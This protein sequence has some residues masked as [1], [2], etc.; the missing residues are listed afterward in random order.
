MGKPIKLRRGLLGYGRMCYVQIRGPDLP[1]KWLLGQVVCE[2]P[3]RAQILERDKVWH[4]AVVGLPD[5]LI[6]PIREAKH[7]AA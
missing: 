5:A 6:R 2:T 7:G 3:L 4:G 1:R